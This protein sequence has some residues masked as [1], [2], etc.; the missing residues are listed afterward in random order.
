MMTIEDEIKN[1]IAFLSHPAGFNVDIAGQLC[2]RPIYET[3]E[4][5]E[6]DWEDQ[7]EGSALEFH[8]IFFTLEEAATFFVEKRHYMCLGLDFN[9]KYFEKDSE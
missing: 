7:A 6:V 8:K 3:I 4:H 2:I 9:A 5:W 1:L